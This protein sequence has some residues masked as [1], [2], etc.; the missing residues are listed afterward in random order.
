MRSIKLSFEHPH[1]L[2]PFRL[3]LSSNADLDRLNHRLADEAVHR[4]RAEA[5]L[6]PEEAK[7]LASL[8]LGK[9]PAMQCSRPNWGRSTR[10]GW[11]RG[12]VPT[13]LGAMSRNIM[14]TSQNCA[15]GQSR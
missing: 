8:S 4:L 3:T 11:G 6:S 13:I 5:I 7:V 15:R 12:G 9:P 14:P 2:Y 1:Y 10:S